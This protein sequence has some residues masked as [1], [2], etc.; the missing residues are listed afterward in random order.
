MGVLGSVG[1]APHAVSAM[2]RPMSPLPAPIAGRLALAL[3]L[4][5]FASASARAQ[6]AVPAEAEP[7]AEV[8]QPPVAA[9]ITEDGGVGDAAHVGDAAEPDVDT[10][11]APSAA[12]RDRTSRDPAAEELPEG[13]SA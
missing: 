12:S 9:S 3:V 10:L 5:V 8:V 2:L 13:A 4:T 1:G 7:Q 6:D 11:G